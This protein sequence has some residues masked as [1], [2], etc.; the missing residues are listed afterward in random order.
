MRFQQK[1]KDKAKAVI[2]RERSAVKGSRSR[3][4]PRNR[5]YFH[6]RTHNGSFGYSVWCNK[7]KEIH[8]SLRDIA[9][10]LSDL[11]EG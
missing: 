3:L 10:I 6:T 1:K 11:G 5:F 9:P 2:I 8:F 7:K 4:I